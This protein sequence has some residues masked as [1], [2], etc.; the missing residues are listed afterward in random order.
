MIVYYRYAGISSCFRKEAGSHGRDTLGIFRVHQFEKIEQFAIVSP[1]GDE[2][3]K[4]FDSM[5]N[6]AEM[7]YQSVSSR[8]SPY[9]QCQLHHTCTFY[10]R[11][12]EMFLLQLNIP[13]HIINIVTGA[14][15]NAAAMKYDLEAYFPASKTYRELVSCSNCTDYQARRLN[16]RYG[17]AKV[18]LCLHSS[19]TK[20]VILT[21]ML[22][23]FIFIY[24]FMYQG[25]D[26]PNAEKEYVHMLNATLCALTRV[27][28]V[29]VETY[30]TPDG[31][32]IPEALVPYMGGIE[33]LPF[34]HPFNSAEI[35][36]TTTAAEPKKEEKK[37]ETK[38][39]E[40]KKEETKGEKKGEK[41][42]EG[43]KKG[44]K[45]GK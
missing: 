26:D 1:I 13:Y 9:L 21:R 18:C 36:T 27:M 45:G 14:L 15:N 43:D 3:W 20:I 23:F 29:I 34:I 38:K 25:K 12:H 42:E 2:S 30:Q 4:T 19:R 10:K 32:R 41:K 6:T 16:V 28:C 5:V 35:A 44:K 37:V 11:I 39:T 7:F 33:F 8:S 24:F 40:G 22:I 31:V 17:T